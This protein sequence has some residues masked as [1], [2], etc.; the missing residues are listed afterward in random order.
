[1]PNGH[2]VALVRLCGALEGF[3][4]RYGRW[5]KR[6]LIFPGALDSLEQLLTPESFERVAARIAL[7]PSDWGPF[8]AEDD[9]GGR[10]DFGQE[11]FPRSPVSP[12][13]R[14]WLGTPQLR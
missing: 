12:D 14:T 9:F 10:Y 13:A 3:R 7:V 8:I 2:D 11:G 4:E 6:V 1:M 5:P